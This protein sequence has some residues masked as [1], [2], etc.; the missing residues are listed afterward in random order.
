MFFTVHCPLEHNE[1][2]TRTFTLWHRPLPLP[3]KKKTNDKCDGSLFITHSNIN[4]LSDYKR[5]RLHERIEYPNLRR[6]FKIFK[7]NVI[8]QL[9]A[10]GNCC[11]EVYPRK[12]F[13]GANK[14]DI[15]PGIS[16]Y[17]EFPPRSVRKKD[18][19]K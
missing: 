5:A 13:G 17:P 16:Y 12:K 2:E 8:I 11:W 3:P 7:Q 6:G 19:E 15:K 1:K 10:E 14:Q 18:C 4:S 9:E